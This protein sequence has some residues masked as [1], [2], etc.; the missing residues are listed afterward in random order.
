MWRGIV[1]CLSLLLVGC[2]TTSNTRDLMS[3]C[4]AMGGTS[5][6]SPNPISGWYIHE[7][8]VPSTPMTLEEIKNWRPR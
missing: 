8:W 1:L 6:L 5:V 4:R 7:C 3:E 2:E